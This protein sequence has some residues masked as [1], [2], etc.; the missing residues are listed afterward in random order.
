LFQKGALTLETLKVLSTARKARNDLSHEGRHPTEGEA[1]SA[2]Q[3]ACELLSVALNGEKPP[4]LNL[5]LSD[6]ALS[7]PFASPR[8]LA[9]EPEFWMEIPKLPGEQELEQAEARLRSTFRAKHVKD[10][11]S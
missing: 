10:K 7:D 9:G 3:S 8:P 2:Y 5:D 4:L 6:H 1:S 11:Q